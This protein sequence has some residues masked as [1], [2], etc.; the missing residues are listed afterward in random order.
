M[1]KLLLPF[2]LCL[3]LCVSG[4]F[5]ASNNPREGG[6]FG[7]SPTAYEKRQEERRATLRG[8]ETQTEEEKAASGTLEKERTAKQAQVAK[9]EKDLK[10]MEKELAAT[11]R[12]LN[13][14]KAEDAETGKKLQELKARQSSLTASRNALAQPGGNQ[15]EKKKELE[16]LQREL[17]KLEEEAEA[18]SRL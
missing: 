4:C 16:F 7:Y 18:L 11:S 12:K 3:I 10:A 1:K 9:Q 2:G 8:L 17:R 5:G 13:A 6:L 15:E 14:I